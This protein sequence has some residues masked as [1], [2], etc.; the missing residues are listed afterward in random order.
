MI[1]ATAPAIVNT[2]RGSAEDISTIG[3]VNILPFMYT[4]NGMESL[5]YLDQTRH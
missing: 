4:A 2:R 5:S 3:T 1:A